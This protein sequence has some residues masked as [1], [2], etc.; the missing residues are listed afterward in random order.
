MRTA[1]PFARGLHTDRS[2]K[3]E[4][5]LIVLVLQKHDKYVH[6]LIMHY[7]YANLKYC[8]CTRG[9]KR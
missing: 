9:I 2:L 4:T 3:K 1:N 6:Q 7:V 5:T 8:S